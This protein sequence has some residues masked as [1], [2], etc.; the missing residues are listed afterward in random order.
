MSIDTVGISCS[1][2][3]CRTSDHQYNWFSLQS[4]KIKNNVVPGKTCVRPKLLQYESAYI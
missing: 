2:F 3:G 1:L 4:A